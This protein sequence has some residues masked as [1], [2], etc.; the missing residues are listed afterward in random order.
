MDGEEE[1]H[2]HHHHSHH[3]SDLSNSKYWWCAAFVCIGL[4]F[5]IIVIISIVYWGRYDNFHEHVVSSLTELSERHGNQ[6][7]SVNSISMATILNAVGLGAAASDRPVRYHASLCLSEDLYTEGDAYNATLHH[8]ELPL[9]YG[10]LMAAQ[11]SRNYH[12][13]VEARLGLDLNVDVT[14]FSNLPQALQQGERYMVLTYELLSSYPHFSTVRL[15][16][17]ATDTNMRLQRKTNDIV[18]CTNNQEMSD[19]RPCV[20]DSEG[21]GFLFKED[22]LLVPMGHSMTERGGGRPVNPGNRT[23]TATT[24]PL[25]TQLSLNKKHGK[26]AEIMKDVRS[27]YLIFFRQILA[28]EELTAS[29]GTHFREELVLTAR[30]FDCSQ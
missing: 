8:Q 3:D 13:K 22:A 1:H 29:R 19:K 7:Q 30:P 15:I 17:V 26:K 5:F 11:E 14:R 12:Y 28:K 6:L 21:D 24:K 27:Y 4:F 10:E 18:L 25:P 23:N 9:L 20:V 2:H 16:E